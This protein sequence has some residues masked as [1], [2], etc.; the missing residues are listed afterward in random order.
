M[1][2]NAIR[3]LLHKQFKR[4]TEAGPL[5]RVEPDREE[6]WRIYLA[7]IPPEHQQ[8]NNCNCCKS[9]L[10]QFGGIVG[11]DAQGVMSTLWDFSPD[12]PEYAEAIKA[13]GKYIR[14]LPV[15]GPFLNPFVRCGT[16]K[17]PD[18]VRAV[19]WTHFYVDMPKAYVK[20][21]DAIGPFC[22]AATA[23]K[24]V[25]QRSITEITDDAVDTVLELI[26]QNSLY[27]GQEFLSTLTEFRK[28]RQRYKSLPKNEVQ[29]S[30][31]CW[32]E[33]SKV[34]S[35]VARV[36]NTSIGTLLIDLSEGR[37]LD[38]AVTAFERVVAP[39][40]YKRPTAPVTPRMIDAA[41]QRLEELGLMGALDRRL[42]SDRD[43]TVARA[44]FVD[45]P[46]AK[47]ADIFTQIK[48]DT[49]VNPKSLAKVEEIGIEDF[50]SGVLP[51]AKSIRVLL[52]NSHLPNFVSLVGP[53][54]AGDPNMLKWANN[55][56]WSYSGEVADSIKERV[57]AAGGN[58]T[59]VIRVSLSWDNRDDLDLHIDEPGGYKIYFGNKRRPSPTGGV[60]DADANGG[61]GFME[62]PV[63][64][65][66]WQN[67]PTVEG[68]YHIVVHQYTKWDTART[69]WEL[70]V[71]YGGEIYLF[72]GKSNGQNGH[73]HRVAT[74]NFTRK[75]GF[76]ITADGPIGTGTAAYR[77]RDKWG[78]KTGTFHKVRAITL[79]PNYWDGATGNKHWFFFLEGCKSDEKT[80]GF[81]NE[82][83]R[84]DLDKDRKVFEVLGGKVTV[85]P[86]DN[87]LSGIGF[88]ETVRKEMIVE[89]EGAFKRTL[90]IKF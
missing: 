65:I 74:F 34:S 88:S 51:T 10:R 33:S 76:S 55:F 79:S 86:V 22:S 13:V 66:C 48:Q 16:E 9:F 52:D 50:I 80:R 39:S 36:R 27:R 59:G 58:V 41:K 8:S 83:L 44:L 68:D 61:D 3:E 46:V 63:E 21:A 7:A 30:N 42:L 38:S 18:K 75:G 26:G 90:R 6:I 69:G 15:A 35:A 64:N 67:A 43:L 12:D 24:E 77:S 57:K 89:V 70:E 4:I 47:A 49:I 54:N 29:R 37:D 56:S 62:N 14:S 71:E 1:A 5:F 84:Q 82:F 2:F 19:V 31:W 53:K 60:L 32:V 45:R 72:S 73:N 11:I 40:N 17:N 87:E 25:L 28:L 85:E 78:L 81:Y 20:P 23:N